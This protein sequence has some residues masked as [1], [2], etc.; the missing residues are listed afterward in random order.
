M[1]VLALVAEVKERELD[2][3]GVGVSGAANA[4]VSSASQFTGKSK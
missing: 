3:V 1:I 4:S 2:P